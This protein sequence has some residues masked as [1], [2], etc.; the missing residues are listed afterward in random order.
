MSLTD[1]EHRAIEMLG[2]VWNLISTQIVDTG[3]SME[4]DL[5]EAAFHIHA[6]Q[7][8]IGSQASA[9]E[10]P[11]RYRLLGSKIRAVT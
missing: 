9:R 10:Y 6:L 7:R 4:G 8:M 3:P 5:Q 1:S 2:D 11:G